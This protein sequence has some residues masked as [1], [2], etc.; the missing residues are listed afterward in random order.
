M[1][2]KDA[3]GQ[4]FRASK[5]EKHEAINGSKV[6]FKNRTEFDRVNHDKK[7]ATGQRVEPVTSPNGI[8]QL[9]P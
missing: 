2:E 9:P 1:C 4:G 6:E 3:T 8:W 7:R 5:T